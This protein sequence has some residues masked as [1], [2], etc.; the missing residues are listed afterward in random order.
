[1]M[2]FDRRACMTFDNTL[3]DMQCD[4]LISPVLNVRIG[5]NKFSFGQTIIKR[6]TIQTTRNNINDVFVSWKFV[7]RISV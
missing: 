6:G 5:I 3:I 2:K 1:M 7:N 4:D